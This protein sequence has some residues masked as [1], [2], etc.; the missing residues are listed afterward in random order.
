M[1]GS[2][3]SAQS[4]SIDQTSQHSR[5]STITDGT[6]Y[7]PLTRR[8]RRWG[9]LNDGSNH[10][11]DHVNANHATRTAAATISSPTPSG[12]RSER[13]RRRSSIKHATTNIEEQRQ[14]PQRHRGNSL[15][16]RICR[17]KSPGDKGRGDRGSSTNKNELSSSSHH[18][19]RSKS[20]ICT[21]K[22]PGDKGRGDRGSSNNKNELSSSS[23]HKHRSKSVICTRKIPGDKGRGDRGSS[24]NKNELSSSRH[25]HRSKSVTNKNR[26]SRSKSNGPSSSVVDRSYRSMRTDELLPERLSNVLGRSAS[27]T[28]DSKLEWLALSILV[29]E[30]DNDLDQS[31]H[32]AFAVVP[33]HLLDPS[34]VRMNMQ[35]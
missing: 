18:K 16:A 19:H 11:I 27:N 25:K 2:H 21:R 4:K 31:L 24:S 35:W 20:V 28:Q 8:G 34:N 9:S 6:P 26:R 10:N 15:L 17:R 1:T 33:P 5:A 14:M 3:K 12:K 13:G 22:S 32:D 29:A 30:E 7:S 23:R